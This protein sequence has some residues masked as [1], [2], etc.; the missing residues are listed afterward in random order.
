MLFPINFGHLDT[1][2][3]LKGSALFTSKRVKAKT[4]ALSLIP[5]LVCGPIYLH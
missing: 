4:D 1:A 2:V 3:S 5:V